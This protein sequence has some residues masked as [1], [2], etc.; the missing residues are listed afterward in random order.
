MIS[1]RKCLCYI[2]LTIFIGINVFLSGQ[3]P[4]TATIRGEVLDQSRAA[5]PGV[6]VSVHNR[7]TGLDRSA[8]SDHAGNFSIAGLPVSGNYSV[9]AKKQGFADATLDNV[10]LVGGSVA[11]LT[12]QLNASG[13]RTEITVTSVAGQVRADDAQLGTDLDQSTMQATPLLNRRI[14]T[15]P[16]LNSAN[17]PAINQGD[18]FVNQTLFT[19]NG[20]GRRQTYYEV[21][22]ANAI[23]TWGRQTIFTSLPLDSLQEM[24]VLTNAFSAE[25]GRSAGSAV[26]IV[27]RIG[28]NQ[29]HGEFLGLW[30]PSQLSASLSGF[31]PATATSGAQI[32]SDKL[33]QGAATVSG[34]I[35]HDNKTH[36]LLSGEYSS[37]DRGSPV[38]SPIDPGTYVGE[39]RGWLGMARLD[40]EINEK[41]TLFFR[42]G[43]DAFNDTNPSGAVGGNTLPTACSNATPT[44]QS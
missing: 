22:G 41:N 40:H 9:T 42:G 33:A 10:D 28:G 37:Q 13:G 27:T 17:R 26:N 35:G 1:S 34:A 14:T 25:Y 30:R 11:N 29:L 15:L 8:V 36:F 39:Y 6:E 21:D 4:D 24:S 19:T 3:T 23:D 16:L 31:T 12:L 20:A 32:T 38:T 18:L 5:V 2:A 7:L 44:L 43:A